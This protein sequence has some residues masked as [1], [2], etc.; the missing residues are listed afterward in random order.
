M[1]N[2][3]LNAIQAMPDGGK[4][5]VETKMSGNDNN[6]TFELKVSDS[7][8]GI[9]DSILNKIFEPFFTTKEKGT[10][11]GLAIVN[12]II[13]A[14]SGEVIVHTDP[15]IGTTFTV[16]LPAGKKGKG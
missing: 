13:E 2:L 16:K 9:D 5:T 6:K 4:L 1:L 10:G 3:I 12:R 11:L 8:I 14:C 7:G 15:Y